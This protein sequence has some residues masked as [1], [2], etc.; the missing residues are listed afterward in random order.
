MTPIR[1]V[2]RS[3]TLIG[4]LTLALASGVAAQQAAIR[5]SSVIDA[6]QLL[7]D[8]QTLSAD[9]M[10]GRQ[11]GTPGGDR[12]RA[13]V[14]ARFKASGIAP[15]G[16]SYESPFTFTAGGGRRG[17]APPAAGATPP[18]G[19]AAPPAGT[20]QTATD[21]TGVNVVGEI[22]GTAAT[23][24]YIVITAH[25]DHIGVRN[26]EV[27]NGADDNASGTAALFALAKHFSANRPANSLLFVAFDAEE[28]GLRGAR[29]FVAKPPVDPA[30]MILNLNLD[31]IGRD[32]DDKLFV[33][34]THAQPYLKPMIE[35]VA[36]G[37]S[38]KLLMG[39]DDPAQKDVENWMGSSDHAAFFQAKIPALY[40]GVEDFGN[41]HKATDDYATMTHDF[42]VR[43]VETMVRVVKEFDASLDAVAKG[44]GR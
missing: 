16:A 32:P 5:S 7:K 11:V 3:W 13:Y 8:L 44:S 28:S 25:Y 29:A 12:A 6:A 2:L 17:A 31:M 1:S 36:A 42:Y 24:R 27:F 26:G 10:E 39:H 33:V 35:R 15:I 9:E 14:I 34:G 38:I 19:G 43:V 22:A 37:A 20:A 23:R 30:S 40:F 4:A 21:R 41:H 18:V